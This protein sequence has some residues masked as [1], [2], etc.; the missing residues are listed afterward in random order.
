[1]VVA[2]SALRQDIEPSTPYQT[3]PTRPDSQTPRLPD[4]LT[5]CIPR[6][7]GTWYGVGVLVNHSTE[8]Y[9]SKTDRTFH[10]ARPSSKPERETGAKTFRL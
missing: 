2:S 3:R 1:M 8:L 5:P 7:L 6:Y 4:S 10:H 9:V